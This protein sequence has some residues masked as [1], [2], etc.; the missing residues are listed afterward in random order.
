[1]G[2]DPSNTTSL[3]A[4]VAAFLLARG[5]H[6][7]IGYGQWGLVWPNDA[8]AP[9]PREMFAHEYG[10][11]VESHCRASAVGG[12][13]FERQWTTGVVALDCSS[14]AAHLPGI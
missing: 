8:S 11:P 14:F 12:E 13:R 3:R 9:L 7:Y 2:V 10:S 4:N 6:A 1:M 5:P